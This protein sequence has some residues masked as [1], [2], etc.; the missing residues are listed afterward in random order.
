LNVAEH[1]T[2]FSL[3][4]WVKCAIICHNRRIKG[5]KLWVGF[6]LDLM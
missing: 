6:H 3:K 4:F 2:I 5:E 1:N